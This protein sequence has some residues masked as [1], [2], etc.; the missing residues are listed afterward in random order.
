MKG[1]QGWLAAALLA[2]AWAG[3]PAGAAAA[4][5]DGYFAAG[6]AAAADAGGDPGW[7][8]WGFGRLDLG[9]GESAFYGETLALL[10]LGD[11]TTPASLVLQAAAREGP[12]RAT[13]DG[14][15]VAQLYGKFQRSW[16]DR[17]QNR[18]ALRLGFFFLP[19]S[20]E[21]VEAGW[22]S[23]YTLTFSALNTWI[24]EEVRPT[25]LEASYSRTWGNGGELTAS[26]TA[27]GGNDV[28]GVLLAWRGF[29]MSSRVALWGEDLPLPPLPSLTV[30]FPFQRA[31]SESFGDDLDGRPG[32]WLALRYEQPERFLVQ[33]DHWD[34][35]GDRRLHADQYS[36]ATRYDHLAFEYTPGGG[37]ALLGEWLAGQSGMGLLTQPHV[38]IDFDAA[39]LMASYGRGPFR[40]SLRRDRFEIEERDLV[41]EPNGDRGDAWTAALLVDSPAKAWRFGLEWLQVDGEHPAAATLGADPVASH[42]SIRLELR[43]YFGS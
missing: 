32:Y 42:R 17:D 28:A 43:Y 12:E 1:G 7:R 8:D 6:A 5:F 13:G 16:G 39:Y 4:A 40:F 26:A 35:R 9:D 15:G 18:L 11:E 19:S 21:N 25:G 27:F 36:W 33:A 24:G 31:G 23:P 41:A 30:N 38:D 37:F 34:N 10:S 3:C 22:S 20:R 2:G 29:A 14:A